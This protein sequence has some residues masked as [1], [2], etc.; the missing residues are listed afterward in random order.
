MDKVLAKFF[1]VLYLEYFEGV[2]YMLLCVCL[3]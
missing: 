1:M 3:C 2:L